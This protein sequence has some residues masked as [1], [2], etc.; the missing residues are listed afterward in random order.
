M[1]R[2]KEAL[3]QEPVL[4]PIDYRDGGPVIIMVDA[5]PVACGWA[6]GQDN[7][8]GQRTAA[9]FGAKV[10]NKMQRDY[11]QIKRELYGLYVALWLDRHYLIGTEV[12]VET[13]CKGLLRMVRMCDTMDIAMLRWIAYV[14]TFAPD[15]EELDS[16]DDKNANK[17]ASYI[18]EI[19]EMEVL[20]FDEERY[21]GEL[22]EI[23]QFL[24]MLEADPSWDEQKVKQIRKEAYKFR[25]K[26]GLLWKLPSKAGR[27]PVRVV[28]TIDERNAILK[29][30]HEDNDSGHRGVHGTFE[31]IWKLYWWPKMY[32]SVA[33]FIGS[34][35]VCQFYLWI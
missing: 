1:C 25:L 26:N 27:E 6:I 21:M 14:K 28:G 19:E 29:H 2:L 16:L 12:V 22:K 33:E 8:N 11:A 13:N 34:C 23:G 31:R 10:F 32:A 9:R 7:S 5:S 24:S 20:R 18:G 30:C 3:S 35:E 15:Q 17:Y 4:Q